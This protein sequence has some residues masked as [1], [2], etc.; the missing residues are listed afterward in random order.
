MNTKTFK[1]FKTSKYCDSLNASSPQPSSVLRTTL[2]SEL[3]ILSVLMIENREG[4]GALKPAIML[5]SLSEREWQDLQDQATRLPFK[6]ATMIAQEQIHA[7]SQSINIEFQFS[8]SCC[9]LSLIT[10]PSTMQSLLYHPLHDLKSHL[11]FLR[12]HA[13]MMA[14]CR[15]ASKWDQCFPPNA[16]PP[17][18]EW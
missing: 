16:M 17:G 4:K 14:D 18:I 1:T 3:V 15:K 5:D 12:V 13:S 11:L 10:V 2:A 8:I 9:L 6:E 7:Q